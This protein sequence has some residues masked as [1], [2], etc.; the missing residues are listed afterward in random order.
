MSNFLIEAVESRRMMSVSLNP[1]THVL[2]A[3]GTNGSDQIVVTNSGTNVKVSLNG[4]TSTFA[5]SKVAK[6]V[7][8][9]FGGND[10]LRSSDATTIPTALNGGSGVD[11]LRGGGGDDDLTGGTGDDV[12]DGGYGADRMSGGDGVDAVD[13]SHRTENLEI[14]LYSLADT[15]SGSWLHDI[16]I[17]NP[18][19]GDVRGD[20]ISEDT[21]NCRGGSGD[22]VITGNVSNNKIWGNGGND[23]I[24]GCEGN[25]TLVGGAGKD[26]LDGEAGNDLLDAYDAKAWDTVVGGA[27]FDRA[28]IDSVLVKIGNSN[29]WLKDPS[30]GVELFT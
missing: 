23:T 25:D 15:L 27:G 14:N 13:Y 1:A 8:N 24:F 12:M 2:T 17:E 10:S 19:N 9:G 28:K 20:T 22:D 18:H 29:L 16:R 3:S 7:L 30:S 4:A 26:E 11:F 5:K 21:E 6:I